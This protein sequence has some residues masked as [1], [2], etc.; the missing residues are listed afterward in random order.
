MMN[1]IMFTIC[2]VLRKNHPHSQQ[3]TYYNRRP[4]SGKHRSTRLAHAFSRGQLRPRPIAPLPVEWDSGAVARPPSVWQL[5]GHAVRASA[6]SAELLEPRP[7][8]NEI[9]RR[10]RGCSRPHDPDRLSDEG[11]GA[12][13]SGNSGNVGKA[14]NGVTE[15]IHQA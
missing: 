9:R 6:S 15:T 5:R 8:K 7:G 10:K 4:V 11:S 12:D 13:R 14:Q 3:H 2:T 1:R